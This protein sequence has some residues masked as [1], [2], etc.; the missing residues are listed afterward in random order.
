VT[1]LPLIQEKAQI[2]TTRRVMTHGNIAEAG[3]GLF[4]SMGR[5][6]Q[7][8]TTELGKKGWIMALPFT[9]DSADASILLLW[10]V[11][12]QV[13]SEI[14]KGMGV[15]TNLTD[16][17]NTAWALE[18]IPGAPGPGPA[19]PAW[20]QMPFNIGGGTGIV[21]VINSGVLFF[22]ALLL[23]WTTVF[24][25]VNTANDGEALGKK[26]STLMTPLRTLTAASMLIP[27]ST[28][29]SAIQIFV[30][31]VAILSCG[32]ASY[33]WKKYTGTA[34]AQELGNIY[35]SAITRDGGTKDLVIDLYRMGMCVKGYNEA[36]AQ[37]SPSYTPAMQIVMAADMTGYQITQDR[38]SI[39]MGLNTYDAN[40]KNTTGNIC[41]KVTV[42]GEMNAPLQ[43]TGS[44]VLK[45]TLTGIMNPVADVATKQGNSAALTRFSIMSGFLCGAAGNTVCSAPSSTFVVGEFAK[46]KLIGDSLKQL[47]D[48]SKNAIQ[49][50]A[51]A[52]NSADFR[53]IVDDLNELLRTELE[54]VVTAM[55]TQNYQYT[56]ANG[57]TTAVQ[58]SQVNNLTR[59]GWIFAGSYHNQV[60]T[61]KNIL[62]AKTKIT[63]TYQATAPTW[64]MGAVLTDRDLLSAATGVMTEYHSMA[65]TVSAK[66][67]S[68]A[69]GIANVKD[70]LADSKG[71]G[72]QAQ[73]AEYSVSCG[74]GGFK[75]EYSPAE[76]EAATDIKGDFLKVTEG[77]G[78]KTVAQFTSQLG[79]SGIDPIMQIKH[80]GDCMVIAAEFMI[81][82]GHALDGFL[83]WMTA[84][85]KAASD[86]TNS[87]LLGSVGGGY[88]SAAVYSA[89]YAASATVHQ[90]VDMMSPG[91][92]G[93]L[94][95]GYFMGYWIPLIPFVVFTLGVIGWLAGVL[96]A[97]LAAPLWAAMHMTPG[98]DSFIGSQSQ[99][100]LL[101][102]GVFF[103]PI[104]MVVGLIASLTMLY[105]ATW[106]VN[107]SYAL[108][109]SGLQ[110]SA[111]D[112]T[113]IFSV[114]V[115]VLIYCIIIF[116]VIMFCFTLPQKVPAKIMSWI[117]AGVSDFGEAGAADRV[118][119]V[120]HGAGGAVKGSVQK[121]ERD[122]LERQK[123]A[124]DAGRDKERQASNNAMLDNMRAGKS[125]GTVRSESPAGLANVQ[126]R[127]TPDASP[128]MASLEKSVGA[129][130][131]SYGST[132]KA[133][134]KSAWP[135]MYATGATAVRG[136]R[137]AGAAATYYG[138]GAVNKMASAFNKLSGTAN[139]TGRVG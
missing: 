100:Y 88:I 117:G 37:V 13:V 75:T 108:V 22:A 27:T 55:A 98:G 32:L 76:I 74:F 51:G 53:K 101:I 62:R 16:L 77:F 80:A 45:P 96:E 110:D 109:M 139:Q 87:T 4:A 46:G 20:S 49:N 97:V 60:A 129:S 73:G 121:Y 103:R 56:D 134:A 41:G 119:G 106:L 29:F 125:N 89:V 35:Q 126:S 112:V 1:I 68:D 42:N 63:G 113:G 78:K 40:Q 83:N 25:I 67:Y 136:A 39:T 58:S 138:K 48:D 111:G 86:A 66:A 17:S 133:S 57:V 107:K 105:P 30:L 70:T 10:S 8:Y 69:T 28:G 43:I 15:V 95:L 7:I 47:V 99:G 23:S 21:S 122:K 120:A 94:Y 127:S 137:L 5:V 135:A 90:I 24:G 64:D 130:N 50:P 54:K 79:K 92:H 71:V 19:A 128:R 31:I 82:G 36:L 65:D 11:F 61:V 52:V 81:V 38:M 44:A 59:G 132:A 104:L 85:I 93:L 14:A 124:L 114:V 9:P 118:G 18:M 12:G 34:M 72:F 2:P 116:Q 115:F 91:V 26:W 102:L 84:T 131:A 123:A 3:R 33:G 6:D